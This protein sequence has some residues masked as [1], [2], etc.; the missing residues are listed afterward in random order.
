MGNTKPNKHSKAVI[1][2][3]KE[4]TPWA[5]WKQ[6]EQIVKDHHKKQ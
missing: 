6:A 2:E 4:H 1:K 3:H 5:T